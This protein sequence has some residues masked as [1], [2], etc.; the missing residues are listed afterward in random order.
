VREKERG[1]ERE[2][3]GKKERYIGG[4]SKHKNSP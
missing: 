2:G 3:E 1:R 4:Y